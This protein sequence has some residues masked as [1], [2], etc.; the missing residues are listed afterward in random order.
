MG[1][2]CENSRARHDAQSVRPRS[3]VPGGSS[4][5]S[6]A[7]VAACEAAIWIS[8]AIPA[9]RFASR[10][11]LQRRRLQTDLRTRFALRLDRV[12]VEPRSDRT[13]RA[14]G[15]RRRAGLRRD[16]RPRPDGRDV[17]RPRRS[18]RP[19][20]ICATICAALRVGIVRE[21]DTGGARAASC[22]AIYEARVCRSAAN[23]A[24]NSSRSSLP[25]AKYGLSTYYLIA[26][27]ECS[28]NLARFDGVRYGL[29]VD[30]ARRAARCTKARA[31]PASAP[32]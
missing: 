21:F 13:V 8:A 10:R 2:S 22:D 15:R 29:R 4:G 20:R 7:A 18:R 5:G 16:G 27:A 23:S 25:T 28:S 1:S 26:P 12:R 17:D 31:P 3:R 19:P 14:L 24:P 6:A 30:G 9:V 32:R 11:V